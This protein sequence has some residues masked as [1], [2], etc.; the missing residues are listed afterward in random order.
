M[1]GRLHA[2]GASD[3]WR[4]PWFLRRPSVAICRRTDLPVGPSCPCV[5]FPRSGR[6]RVAESESRI[7]TPILWHDQYV[8]AAGRVFL[9][10]DLLSSLLEFLRLGVGNIC[11]GL[12]IAVR[13][14]EPRALHL[15]HNAVSTAEGVKDI[16]H[17]KIEIGLFAWKQAVPASPSYCGT[18][19]GR[20]RRAT[21]AGNRPCAAAAHPEC[22]C[23]LAKYRPGL[24]NSRDKRR[25]ASRRSQNRCH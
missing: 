25:S 24:D 14:R 15:H 3:R 7:F 12:R 11:K 2:G 16:G 22:V 18:W 4:Q 20:V 21:T 5:I 13:Q 10:E 9:T 8:H 6:V 17:R 19:R 23:C 1:R